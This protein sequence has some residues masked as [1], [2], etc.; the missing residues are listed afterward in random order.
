MKNA[1]ID[2]LITTYRS[3]A[4]CAAA[5]GITRQAFH[6]ALHRG[7]LSNSAALHAAALLNIDPGRALL[8]NASA[9]PNPTPPVSDARPTLP[10]QPKPPALYYVK[11]SENRNGRDDNAGPMKNV[12][13]IASQEKLDALDLIR[14]VFAVARIPADSPR[15]AYY[16]SRWDV[17][18][19]IARAKA[20]GT[21]AE[22]VKNCPPIDPAWVR[23]VPAALAECAAF[24]DMIRTPARSM[25]S[26]SGSAAPPRKRQRLVA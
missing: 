23:F 14:W 16:V 6:A 26:S 12:H 20:A 2:A 22:M 13:S 25:R 7:R 24:A 3:V 21:F 4:A 9:A 11:S 19:K 17:P 8:D 15:F 5:L 1:L 10:T 18:N